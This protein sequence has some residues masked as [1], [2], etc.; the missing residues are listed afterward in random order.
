MGKK[1]YFVKVKSITALNHDVLEIITEKPEG[2]DFR[3]GQATEMAINKKGWEDENR[4]FTFTNLPEEDHLEFVIKTY[5]SHD[6]VTDE[7]LSVKAGDELILNEVFGAIEYR[8]KGAFLAGGSGVTPF[9]A[10][11]KS[12][13]AKKKLSGNSL[14]FANKKKEDIFLKDTLERM[15]GRKYINLLSDESTDEYPK[16]HIDKDFLQNT[17]SDFNQYF[18]LCGPP[19]MMDEI[20]SDLKDLGVAEKNI[21]VE[22]Y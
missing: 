18:Y 22:E 3:P 6:G 4:P 17:F 19:E 1:K 12:L 7:L 8:G 14:V 15:L 16:G 2:Y 10:I 21:V 5:P 13:E 20:I 11:L 9:I